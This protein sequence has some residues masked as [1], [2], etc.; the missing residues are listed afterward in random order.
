MTPWK[1]G[2]VSFSGK[3]TVCC[4]KAGALKSRVAAMRA[5]R[6]GSS[7]LAGVGMRR[8]GL[9]RVLKRLWSALKRGRP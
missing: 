9:A 3:V 5:K 6:M 2:V 8:G 7:S 1:P 4:A